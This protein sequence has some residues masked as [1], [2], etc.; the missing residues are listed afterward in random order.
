MATKTILLKR[1][2]LQPDEFF[3]KK[4]TKKGFGLLRHDKDPG[5]RDPQER[6]SEI[7]FHH[8]AKREE[9]LRVPQPLNSRKLRESGS[10]L[11]RSQPTIDNGA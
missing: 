4:R 10:L 7:L 11:G 3:K 5:N 6:I 2:T 1:R 8:P 9:K